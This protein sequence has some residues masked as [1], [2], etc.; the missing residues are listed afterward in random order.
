MSGVSRIPARVS[1][2]LSTSV[3][4]ILSVLSVLA[5]E[6]DNRSVVDTLEETVIAL[7]DLARAKLAVAEA[8]LAW[9]GALTS[10]PSWPPGTDVARLD[11]AVGALEDLLAGRSALV[12]FRRNP[13]VDDPAV[14]SVAERYRALPV[15]ARATAVGSGGSDDAVSWRQRIAA[16]AGAATDLEREVHRIVQEQLARQRR[17]H[18]MLLA[19]W[20]TFLAITG[21]GLVGL[22]TARR[23]AERR[24]ATAERRY[25]ALEA[26]AAVGIVRVDGVG[27]VRE[28]TPWWD[29]FLGRQEGRCVGAEWW[30]F[31]PEEDRVPVRE[32]WRSRTS[33]R[34]EFA[35]EIRMPRRGVGG[36]RGGGLQAPGMRRRTTAGSV[37]SWT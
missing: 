10:D 7:D 18:R 11:E 34:G 4:S 32:R 29:H 35:Q 3:F 36:S 37:P 19:A 21:L 5:L 12:R 33:E 23:R 28:A 31:L 1:G 22:R 25:E 20:S 8:V 15:E 2:W 13:L 26:L 30:E 6:L 14:D 24:R 16:L 9:E 27:R 17:E